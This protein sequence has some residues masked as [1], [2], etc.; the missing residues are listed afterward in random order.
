VNLKQIS[1][2]KPVLTLVLL[3]GMKNLMATPAPPFGNTAGTVFDIIRTDDPSTFVCL[4]YKGREERDIWDKRVEDEPVINTYVF[5]AQFSDG[6]SIKV[7][8]NPEF[9]SESAAR[10][11]AL[12]YVQPLGQLPTSLRKGIRRFS[13]HKGTK[14][15]HA[16][17]EQIIVYAGTAS[18]RMGYKHL[19]E[20][21]FHESVHA[22]W[23]AEH[24]L[25]EGW[26]QAQ[27]EDDRFLTKYGENSPE[28]E[29][30]AETALFAFAILHYPARFPPA[31]TDATV[32]AVP[33]RIAYIEKLLPKGKPL[34]YSVGE[35]QG[36]A[37]TPT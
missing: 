19:E 15:F 32:E 34:V 12:R 35:P 11:E 7:A 25:S 1:A 6:T 2:G 4:E 26:R 31:D 23:D 22:S 14:G 9:G 8:I 13:V 20:S 29:D 21:V 33:N 10:E 5:D 30:L 24:R 36:C 16:G 17:D 18:E 3:A 27:Q 37:A 28:R